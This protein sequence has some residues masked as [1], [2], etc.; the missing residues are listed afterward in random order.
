MSEIENKIQK[1]IERSGHD[2]HSKVSK[3]FRDSGWSVTDNHY[4]NDPDSGKAREIDIIAQKEYKVSHGVFDDL[5]ET[6]TIKL[7]IEC[8]YINSPTVFWFKSRDIIKAT[9]LSKDN[10]ILN[11]KPDNYVNDMTK[12]HYVK[13]DQVTGQW[14]SENNDV[15]AEAQHQVLKAM[16]FFKENSDANNY[17]ISYPMIV[18]NDLDQVFKRDLPPKN[19]SN[20]EE[21][22]QIETNYSFKN[23]KKE[24]IT[25]YFLIDVVSLPVL[26]SFIEELESKDIHL[27]RD[28]LA[29][30]LRHQEQESR[31]SEEASLDPYE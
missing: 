23:N 16:L 11:D 25:K 28:S 14:Q 15:F 9:E 24:N 29:Y 27:L 22:F 1:I 18:I 6:I 4:Y 21:K 3:E 7:F 30:D 19:H 26:G 17:E 10:E 2:F 20:I 31:Y 8:K 12:H 5:N 13:L